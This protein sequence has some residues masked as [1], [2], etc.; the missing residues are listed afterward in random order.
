VGASSKITT[1]SN[2]DINSGG[3]NAFSSAGNTDVAV[4][5][6]YKETA[7]RIDMNGPTARIATPA[8][9][10]EPLKPHLNPTTSTTAGWDNRY[11]GQPVASIMKRIPMHEPWLLHENQAPQL[12][13]PKDTDR[14][15]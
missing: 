15:T 9:P 6:N 7:T 13:T 11:Q 5:G 3:N 4:G 8:N 2:L 12:L 1:T 14:E 10:I